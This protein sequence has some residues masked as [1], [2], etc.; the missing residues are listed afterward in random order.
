MDMVSSLE[1]KDLPS[2]ARGSIQ[3]IQKEGDMVLIPPGW[4]H[5][6]YSLTPSIAVAGQYCNEGVRERVCSHIMSWCNGTGKEEE[7]A[8]DEK[9]RQKDED[10][11][12]R[13]GGEDLF[14]EFYGASDDG[15]DKTK[16]CKR[17][18][19]GGCRT[20]SILIQTRG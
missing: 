11:L 6:V 18:N 1:D 7:V 12:K 14:G 4:H 13:E 15:D 2:L 5:Q 17:S 8:R 9:Q 10:R 19:R 3:I 16:E 20:T